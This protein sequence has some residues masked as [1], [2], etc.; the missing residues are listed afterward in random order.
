M[1]L[2]IFRWLMYTIDKGRPDA[3]AVTVLV[4]V[5]GKWHITLKAIF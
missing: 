3:D 5:Y 2:P 4:E 1:V